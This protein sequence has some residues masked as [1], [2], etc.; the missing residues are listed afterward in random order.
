MN[1]NLLP[2]ALALSVLTAGLGIAGAQQAQ[3]APDSNTPAQTA[4]D[5][6]R[7]HAPNPHR[8][9]EHLAK[10]L[11][12]TPDQTAKLEPILAQRD[13]QM[14][15]LHANTAL[16]PDDRHQQMRSIMEQTQQG[17]A[18]VLT[19]D[20]LSQLK[21]MHHEQRGGQRG[22]DGEDNTSAPTQQPS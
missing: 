11:N 2:K 14:Q 16:S 9:A 8:Q 17:M 7:H 10:Q 20:Q 12:L 6:P 13:Q 19:P 22:R 18:G 5:G 1:L 21:T 4:P 3:P 15:A